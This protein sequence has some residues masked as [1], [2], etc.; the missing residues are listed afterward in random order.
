[1]KTYTIHCRLSISGWKILYWREAHKKRQSTWVSPI[2]NNLAEYL[3]VADTGAWSVPILCS[4]GLEPD[5][6]AA[7]HGKEWMEGLKLD[8]T[9]IKKT[10]RDGDAYLT[11]QVESEESVDKDERVLSRL[12]AYGNLKYVVGYSDVWRD[13]TFQ[14]DRGDWLA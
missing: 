6:V 1:M 2:P 7:M 13:V 9:L 5:Q 10:I 8:D 4:S 12:D 3:M 11:L 14:N